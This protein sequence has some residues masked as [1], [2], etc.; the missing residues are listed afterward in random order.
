MQFMRGEIGIPYT[1]VKDRA[2]DEW[3]PLPGGKEVTISDLRARWQGTRA[4]FEDK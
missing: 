3:R 4:L 2:T 1:I